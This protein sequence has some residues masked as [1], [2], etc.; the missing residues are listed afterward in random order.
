[1]LLFFYHFSPPGPHPWQMEVPRLGIKS[2]LQLPAY[3]T[4]TATSDLSCVCNL[5]H[6]SWQRRIL[7]PLSEARDRTCNLMLPSQI[8]FCYATTGNPRYYF[9]LAIAIIQISKRSAYLNKHLLLDSADTEKDM[10][11]NGF[12]VLSC[13]NFGKL[14]QI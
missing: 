14:L 6:S 5:H 2:E 9:L 3:A 1:M 13:I 7:N 11:K 8:H 12:H 10:C 4:V